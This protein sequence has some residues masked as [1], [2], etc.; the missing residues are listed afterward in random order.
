VN[1]TLKWA[2]VT[3]V[4]PSFVPLTMWLLSLA[5]RWAPQRYREFANMVLRDILKFFTGGGS[6]LRPYGAI[7][8]FVLLG[9][10]LAQLGAQRWFDPKYD[11]ED[12][13]HMWAVPHDRERGYGLS[14][15]GY[16]TAWSTHGKASML[17][18]VD[19]HSDGTKE[20]PTC[21]GEACAHVLALPPDGTRGGISSVD[22]SRKRLK[23][24]VH[25]PAGLVSS[26]SEL[27]TYL[28][29]FAVDCDPPFKRYSIEENVGGQL[30]RGRDI[31]Q[32]GDMFLDLRLPSAA[33]RI[34]Q[35]GIKI[36]M[37][38]NDSNHYQQQTIAV[39]DVD[40]GWF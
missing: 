14:D 28:D 30:R 33:K 20:C 39:D 8:A 19:L 12:S 10:L 21:K 11:F 36:G 15:P 29:L 32:E 1:Q 24:T 13:A 3:F 26:N 4:L 5:I 16:N 40:W 17:L 22:L 34:C 6:H 2:L 35:M 25:V 37:N 7:Y 27:R 23:A 18:H 31:L 38:E 9:G